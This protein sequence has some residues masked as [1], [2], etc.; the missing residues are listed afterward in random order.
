M[1]DCFEF[2]RDRFD[3]RSQI[4]WFICQVCSRYAAEH[5]NRGRRPDPW[6]LQLLCKHG[7]IYPQGGSRLAASTNRR[8]KIANLLAGLDCVG[9]HQDGDDGINVTFD[10]SDFDQIASILKPRKLR[11]LSPLHLAAFQLGRD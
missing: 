10:V 9:M 7:H 2:P 1:G 8:G 11:K 4:G 3:D 5:G 6:L